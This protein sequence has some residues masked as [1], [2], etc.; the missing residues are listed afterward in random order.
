MVEKIHHLGV[1]VSS[2]EASIRTYLEGFGL[3]PSPVE[4]VPAQKVKLVMLP[5][6]E[7]RLELLESTDPDGPIGKFLASRGEGVHHVAVAVR[8]IELALARAREAGLR[9]I[10]QEPRAGAHGTRV[11]FV[12]PR[13]THGV[14]LELV[15][16][17]L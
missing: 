9:L 14:L 11:A 13:S 15:E 7:S 6:G 4:E 16:D 1:A 2:L 17:P 12:H 8:D 3:I 10:D 5:V